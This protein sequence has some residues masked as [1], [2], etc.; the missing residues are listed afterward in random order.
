MLRLPLETEFD[1]ATTVA[2]RAGLGL[3]TPELL[4]LGNH[5]T[6][7]LAPLPGRKECVG[8]VVRLLFLKAFL[9]SL[10]LLPIWPCER[11]R[12]SVLRPWLIPALISK[13]NASSLYGISLM[14]E[15]LLYRT[16]RTWPLD[17]SSRS[18]MRFATSRSLLR[19]S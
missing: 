9:A 17:H 15:R 8:N 11:L 1:I 4:H 16:T 10:A 5:T 2:R 3:V 14:A 19:R 13:G 7:K 12:Q 18:M 6:A